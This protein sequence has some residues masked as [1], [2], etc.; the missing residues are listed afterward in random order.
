MTVA[1]R[2]LQGL[3]LYQPHKA[4]NGFTLFTP[5]T[6]IPSNTWLIDMQGRFVH[7]WQLPGWIRLH[8]ELLPNGNLIFAYLDPKNPFKDLPFASGVVVEMDWDGNIVWSYREPFMDGHDR[9]RL[10]NGNTLIQKCVKV[11]EA[12]AA[13]V[14]GGIPGTELDGVMWGYTLQEITPDGKIVWEWT[15]YEHLDPELDAITPAGQGYRHEWP[16]W[17]SL[18]ELPDGNI[19]TCSFNT[20][21]LYI[22]DKVTGDIKWRW[23]Q[24]IISF[25]HN[26]TLLDNGNIL[27][28]DN[29]RYNVKWW[30][31]DYSR[32]IEVNP[33][34]NQIEWEYKEENPVDFYSS[35]ISGCQRLPN[36]NTLICEGAY[37]RLFE[38]TSSGEMV[39]EYVVPFYARG[40]VGTMYEG[41]TNMTF[42]CFR[43]GPDYPGLQGKKLDLEKLDLWNRL[44]G[45]EAFGPW[46]KPTRRGV[47]GVP[48]EEEEAPVA[49]EAPQAKYEES[50]PSVAQPGKEKKVSSR[51]RLLGY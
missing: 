17:N 8:A 41:P 51:A 37:G 14:K 31:P 25:P 45:P 21:N 23:G 42:R 32:V 11:P 33:S 44:Y 10:K 15:T 4:Y 29:G 22:I 24:G 50:K 26:P 18:E 47:E 40:R 20:S 49:K 5:M 30:P 19:M 3:T 7:R 12:I 34:T 9:A 13:K 35:Y 28:F 2:G 39:W 1:R 48:V 38:V 16:G 43:Y 46:G 36:G 6:G 27:V